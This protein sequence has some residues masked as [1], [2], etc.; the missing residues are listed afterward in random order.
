MLLP[1]NADARGIVTR[2]V[3]PDL[4]LIYQFSEVTV[5]SAVLVTGSVKSDPP[6]AV[7][8]WLWFMLVRSAIVGICILMAY[9]YIRVTGAVVEVTMVSPLWNG[10][11]KSTTVCALYKLFA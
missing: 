5:K 7:D 3:E 2:H 6:V 11:P 1:A 10:H 8:E 4:L 9:S